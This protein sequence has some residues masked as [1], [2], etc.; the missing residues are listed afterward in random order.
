MKK[1]GL[2]LFGFVLGLLVLYV[3]GLILGTSFGWY[4][5]VTAAVIAA[6][7]L[8]VNSWVNPFRCGD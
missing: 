2:A 1:T 8:K 7:A 4:Q 3:C 6:F 5:V